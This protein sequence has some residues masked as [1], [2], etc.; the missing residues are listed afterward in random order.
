MRNKLMLFIVAVALVA[1]GSTK[2]QTTN[3][4][5]RIMK[6]YWALNT[7]TYSQSGEFNVTLFNDATADCFK[8]STWRFIPNNNT[9][10]YTLSGLDCDN[11]EKHFVS[12]FDKIDK[13]SGLYDFLL[14]PTNEKHKSE[15][16]NGFRV[17]LTHLDDTTMQWQQTVSLDGK[18]F[19]IYMNFTKIN[20]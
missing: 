10:I 17:S 14:K 13:D 1:C 16:N 3:L 7:I 18:P 12:T 5:K 19:T 2:T 8:G 6:G 9:G 20:E 4:S 15:T 11:T